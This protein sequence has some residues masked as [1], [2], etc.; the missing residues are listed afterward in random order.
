M[1]LR[2][3]ANGAAVMLNGITYQVNDGE[4]TPVVV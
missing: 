4:L 3:V 1:D 2:S